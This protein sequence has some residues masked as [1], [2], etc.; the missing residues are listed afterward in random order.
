MEKYIPDVNSV[1]DFGYGNG[2]FIKHCHEKG[3]NSFAYDISDYPAPE[4]VHRL[5]SIDDL[6]VD[7]MT[8]FDSLEHIEQEDLVPFL[9]SIKTK[10][11]V[12]SVPWFHQFL[13]KEWFDDWKHRKPNEHFHHFDMHGLVGLL[14]DAN[15]DII[16]VGNEEDVI[17]KSASQWPNILTV[18]ARKK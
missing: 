5:E 10:Y 1:C 8:F 9:K 2:A 3:K 14:Y 15:C 16:H 6:T 12:I 18:I 7:V 17:R 11:F 4:G 13:G